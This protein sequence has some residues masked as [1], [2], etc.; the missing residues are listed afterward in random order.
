MSALA[1]PVFAALTMQVHFQ[2]AQ[3]MSLLAA[4]SLVLS[5]GLACAAAAVGFILHRSG[6]LLAA[7]IV[8]LVVA[9]FFNHVLDWE[10]LGIRMRFFIPLFFAAGFGFAWL[11]RHN[12]PAILAVGAGAV[13]VSALVIPGAGS[14]IQETIAAPRPGADASGPALI[15]LIL[16]GHLG[17]EGFPLQVPGTAETKAGI[18]DFYRRYRFRVYGRAVSRHDMTHNS[19]PET[20][21]LGGVVNDHELVD[22][23][24]DRGFVVKKSSVFRQFSEKGYRIRVYQSDA[25]DYCALDGVSACITVRYKT[26]AWLVNANL[27]WDDRFYVLF[28]AF[29]NRATLWRMFE[30]VY[31]TVR[32]AAGEHGIPLPDVQ[33]NP[34]A[35]PPLTM[36]RML[37]R[38]TRD[39]AGLGR[40][41]VMFAHVML[42]HEPQALDEDCR[43]RR[44]AR[45]WYGATGAD[46]YRFYLK[47]VS[48]TYRLLDGLFQAIAGNPQLA[49][50]TI[51]VHGDHGSRIGIEGLTPEKR[52][53]FT[54]STL[55]A[56]RRPG[57]EPGYDEEINNTT[58]LLAEQLAPLGIAAPP[59]AGPR[60]I[61]HRT[62]TKGPLATARMP[63]F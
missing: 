1:F 38:M 14:L 12:A 10:A 24:A 57:V 43:L 9:M 58:A 8:G 61:M 16:D 42:P 55:F 53:V 22:L 39:V 34:M 46:K 41:T 19:I 40:G 35:Y 49:D 11:T 25:I 29:L 15:H 33:T 27:E 47:Q 50:A 37:E 26:L 13:L 4:E 28:S 44:P 2:K 3:G 20:L 6:R 56:V 30:G 36:I 60:S 52:L 51:I 54:H 7:V 48:C 23:D 45:Q 17:V 59:Q 62:T 5:A 21:N 32:R 63:D 31:H 18:R